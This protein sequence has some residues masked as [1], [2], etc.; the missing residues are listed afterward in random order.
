MAKIMA[1]LEGNI[2]VNIAWC[3]DEELETDTLKNSNNRNVG[4][5]D[6]YENGTFYRDGIEVLTQEEEIWK[7]YIELQDQYDSLTDSYVEGVNSV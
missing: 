1:V 3:S 7:S 2:V 5:G 4:I 6:T